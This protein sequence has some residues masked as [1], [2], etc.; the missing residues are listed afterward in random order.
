MNDDGLYLLIIGK[1]V[2]LDSSDLTFTEGERNNNGFV[3][4]LVLCNGGTTRNIG[5]YIYM[6]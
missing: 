2:F 3:A 5:I 4:A 6:L 1:G